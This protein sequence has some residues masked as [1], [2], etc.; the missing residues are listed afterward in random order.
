MFFGPWSLFEATGVELE[1]MIVDAVSLD[2]RPV[3]DRLFELETGRSVGDVDR[4]EIA[5]SNELALH[6]VEL[7][8]AQPAP[9]LEPLVASFQ[10]EVRHVRQRLEALGATLLP[11]GMHP[12]MS[13]REMRLWPHE[14]GP[15]YAAF[16][17]IFGC[18]GHG[19]ANLQSLH[20]NLPF[21][22]A[23]EFGRLHAA[24]RALLP[25]LPAL[26]ASSPIVEGVVTGILD[27]RLDAYRS[28]ARRVPS[29]TGAVIPEAIFEPDQYRTEVLERMYGDIAPLDTEGVLQ[30]EFLNARGA[31]ARF[32]RGSIEIRVLDVQEC[33]AADLAIAAVVVAALRALVEERFA[34]YEAQRRLE[35][36]ALAA[37]FERALR[38]ADLAEVQ[39]GAYLQLFG[40][41]GAPRTLGDVWSQLIH[42]LAEQGCLDL[43][44]W[45][46]PLSII[47]GEGPLARR[48]LRATGSSP[49][50]ERVRE[51][52]RELSRCLAEGV[53]FR[54]ARVGPG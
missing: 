49:T 17:R 24:V 27:N 44:A 41:F 1:Y 18:S 23:D 46:G 45:E 43:R 7:K 51:V 50:L 20:L 2:V 28:N 54:A 19:W 38:A 14:N 10:A 15:I 21:K 3:A 36:D 42:R 34:S 11:T 13:P 52:Y 30:E 6:V 29:V 47:A 37:I 16:D 8:T 31:I 35:T 5:W 12:W 40:I 32:S 33:P 26:S 48:V 39:D 9:A 53:L 22:T 4:G 25:I